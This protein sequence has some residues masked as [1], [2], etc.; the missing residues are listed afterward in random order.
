VTLI[1]FLGQNLARVAELLAVN[2][3]S[4]EVKQVHREGRPSAA[5]RYG[6]EGLTLQEAFQLTYYRGWFDALA[7]GMSES[8]MRDIH[9]R[10]QAEIAG[11]Q[12]LIPTADERQAILGRLT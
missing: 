9:R 3:G 7:E 4:F 6:R 8:Y 10:I 5:N 11:K 12:I 1:E 2:G